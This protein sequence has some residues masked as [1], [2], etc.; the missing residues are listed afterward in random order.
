MA[1]P[2]TASSADTS[3]TRS[4]ATAAVRSSSTVVSKALAYAVQR[5]RAY[6]VV[7]SNAADVDLIN[8]SLPQL[9]RQSLAVDVRVMLSTLS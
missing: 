9:G 7:G 4:G 3:T 2:A 6:A 1:T 8:L 5:R